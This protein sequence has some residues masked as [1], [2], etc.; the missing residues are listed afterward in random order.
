MLFSP[1]MVIS[2]GMSLISSDQPSWVLSQNDQVR[3]LPG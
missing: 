2:T 1:T 3:Q